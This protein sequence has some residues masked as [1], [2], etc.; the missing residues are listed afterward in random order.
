V[1]ESIEGYGGKSV[2]MTCRAVAVL[3][4]RERDGSLGCSIEPAHPNNA[5]QDSR[6]ERPSCFVIAVITYFPAR[7]VSRKELIGDGLSIPAFIDLSKT[8]GRYRAWT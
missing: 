3:P 4:H 2:V 6:P 5:G 7:S 8:D 1:H